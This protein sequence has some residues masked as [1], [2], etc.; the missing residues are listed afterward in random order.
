MFAQSGPWPDSIAVARDLARARAVRVATLNNESA[1]LNVHRIERSGCATSFRRSSAPAGSACASRRSEIYKR[2]LGMTQADPARTLFIDDRQQNLTPAAALGMQTIHVSVGRRSCDGDLSGARACCALSPRAVAADGSVRFDFNPRHMQLAMVGLGRM[3]G[4]MVERLMRHGHQLVV[5]DRSAD[6]M[7]KYEKLGA[8][9]GGGSRQ[10][11]SRR[12][13]RRAS[14]GSWCRPA[15]RST[16]RSRRWS[17]LLSPGD[18]DHR[19]RQLELPRH[20]APRRATSP[21]RRSSSSTAA[22]AAA[23]GD[24]RTATASWSAAATRR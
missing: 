15:I 5:Y 7:S 14:C 17:P 9:S 3:G 21:S 23:C 16:R 2:V 4:N 19:R 20:D 13:R 6:A 22:R 12:S 8:T 1:E 24:S 18:V 11:A 10:R